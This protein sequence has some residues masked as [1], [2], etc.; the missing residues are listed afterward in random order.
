MN[1]QHPVRPT[2]ETA[3]QLKA[4]LDDSLR[5]LLTLRDELRLELHLAGMEVKTRWQEH[6]EPM[7]THAEAA[8]GTMEAN[9]RGTVDDAIRSLQLFR[10]VVRG[11]KK[12]G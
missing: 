9:A 11:G 3:R 1:T 5:L 7:L 4:H 2:D 6:V 10:E 8:V 12:G